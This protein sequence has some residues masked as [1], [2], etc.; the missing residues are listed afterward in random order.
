[1]NKRNYTH[2]L[3][4]FFIMIS[5][6]FLLSCESELDKTKQRY[7]SSQQE[8]AQLQQEL[9]NCKKELKLYTARE[10][11]VEEIEFNRQQQTIESKIDK[12]IKD[13][14]SA[15][16][17]LQDFIHTLFENSIEQAYS[18]YCSSYRIAVLKYR[19]SK[20]F[21]IAKALKN[22]FSA[23]SFL[24]H[25]IVYSKKCHTASFERYGQNPIGDGSDNCIFAKISIPSAW[26]YTINSHDNSQKQY[27]LNIVLHDFDSELPRILFR[28]FRHSS[29]QR[30]CTDHYLSAIPTTKEAR[31][32]EMQ[33][34]G[35]GIIKSLKK[36]NYYTKKLPILET[37]F[38]K[39][40]SLRTH[41]KRIKDNME[42]DVSNPEALE[43]IKECEELLNNVRQ[44]ILEFKKDISAHQLVE[45]DEINKLLKKF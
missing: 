25:N 28:E 43:R 31:Y 26:G 32:I 13:S 39:I 1:M 7:K 8:N 41:L 23:Q 27:S 24:D 5:S 36:L 12:R 2:L 22:I 3:L 14:E 10:D 15:Y 44:T 34:L 19:D 9:S 16:N 38:S 45:Q 30:I 37:Q 17:N 4:F 35:E 18:I 21:T 11:F 33:A 29:N 40:S 20:N 6:I 42:I